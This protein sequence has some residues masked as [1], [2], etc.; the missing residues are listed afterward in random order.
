MNDPD[1]RPPGVSVSEAARVLRVSPGTIRRR[2]AE[3]TLR[4]ERVIRPQG[5][6]WRVHL[7]D[8]VPAT[9]SVL[10]TGTCNGASPSESGHTQVTYAPHAQDV[11]ASTGLVESIARLIAELAEVRV[12][13]DR[14]SDQLVSM[15]ERTAV[16]ERENGRL[17]A[18]LDAARTQISTLEASTAAAS[19]EPTAEP[20]PARWRVLGP[21]LLAALAIAAAVGLL[22]PVVR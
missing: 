1:V 5:T 3:G 18:E 14:R 11:P 19:A 12:T 22:A 17:S 10:P 16:L 8:D 9:R 15:G 20:P 2:I 6:A 7:P 13:A 4:A 21:W